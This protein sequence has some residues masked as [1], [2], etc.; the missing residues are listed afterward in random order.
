LFYHP[1][2]RKAVCS[3]MNI[4]ADA[5]AMREEMAVFFFNAR[6]WNVNTVKG[7][8]RSPDYIIERND[9]QILVEVG[10]ARKGTAQMAGFDG[11]KL[12]LREQNLMALGFY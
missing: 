12:V 9:E 4:E 6:G 3:S 10:G 11:K 1:N 8:K 5:G 2:L 7:M